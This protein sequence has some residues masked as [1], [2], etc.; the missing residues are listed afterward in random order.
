MVKNTILVI[1][2]I[3]LVIVLIFQLN[4]ADKT[5]PLLS[6]KNSISLKQWNIKFDGLIKSVVKKK[7]HPVY[8][9][10]LV[11]YKSLVKNKVFIELGSLLN[12]IGSENASEKERL[13]AWLNIYN[14]LAM[15]KVVDNIGIKKLSDLNKGL[16]RVWTQDAGIVNGTTVSLDTVEHK[17]IRARF[18][19]PRV[20]FALVCAALSCPDLRLEAFTGE[21][22]EEQLKDQLTVFMKNSKKGLK[23]DRANK[24][25]YLTKI[26]KWFSGDFGDVKKWLLKKGIIT[27]E[28]SNFKIKYLDYDWKLNSL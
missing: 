10:N 11:D 26:M 6:K 21:K 24:V 17:I 18:K 9:T 3:G 1:F 12:S 25:I 7:S 5:Y 14:Y 4:G 20:H 2:G 22:L 27:K 19:E 15:K 28:E 8:K 16:S 23:I 13:A